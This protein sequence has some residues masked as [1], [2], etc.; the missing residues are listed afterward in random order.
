MHSWRVCACRWSWHTLATRSTTSIDAA[1]TAT[2]SS[3]QRH[4]AVHCS[5]HRQLF[6]IARLHSICEGQI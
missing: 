1:C 2:S 4:A 5:R 3:A 6:S